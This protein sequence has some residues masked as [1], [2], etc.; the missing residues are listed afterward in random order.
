[1]K[2]LLILLVLLGTFL[3]FPLSFEP[4]FKSLESKK[5]K[6]VTPII[7]EQD[8][9]DL[10]PTIPESKYD[11]IFAANL[12]FQS[13]G[14]D[15]PVGKPNGENYFKA[16]KFGQRHHLG[17]DWNGLGGGNTDLGDPIYSTSDGL[18]VFSQKVCCG[19]GNIIRVVHRLPDHS[20]YKY[21]ESVYAHMHDKLVR[22]GDL[23]RRGQK[24]GTIGTAEGKY[25]AHLHFEM[26][27]FVGMS[28]GPGYSRDNFGYLGPTK[29]I[30]LNRPY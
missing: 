30:N 14:F 16:L 22:A 5:D 6:D 9:K 25:S 2:H 1:M 12:S 4:L 26:R 21:V 10:F 11:S 19:W 24:I 13:D 20:K 18:V 23:V 8:T 3:Y 27:D 15:F 29:F 17:E 28:L 7:I